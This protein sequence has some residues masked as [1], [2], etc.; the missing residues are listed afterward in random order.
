[1]AQIPVALQLYTVREDAARDFLGTLDQVAAIGYIGVE[2][3]GYGP[4]TPLQISLHE[5]LMRSAITVAGSHVALAR[6]ENELDA[7]IAECQTL[8]CP[9][10]VCPVLPAERRNE[11][12]FRA[13]ATSL[14]EIGHAARR[15]GSTLLSQPR[16]RV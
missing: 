7:V 9:T 11:A 6:L 8:Q 14:N 13:L 4:L 5:L 12:G 10:I 16:I 15:A 2:L 1:M 3:A